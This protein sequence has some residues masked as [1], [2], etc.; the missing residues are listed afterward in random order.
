MHCSLTSKPIFDLVFG[1]SIHLVF[2][3][4][5]Y[6]IPFVTNNDLLAIDRPFM[7]LSYLFHLKLLCINLSGT[8]V[9]VPSEVIGDVLVYGIAEMFC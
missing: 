8:G 6:V 4:Y 5:T 9:Y 2:G 3:K 7:T 1:I